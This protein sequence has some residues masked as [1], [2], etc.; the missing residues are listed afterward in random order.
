MKKGL[1]NRGFG[2]RSTGSIAALEQQQ[3]AA[4]VDNRQA[5]P[6]RSLGIALLERSVLGR[7][8]DGAGIGELQLGCG[9][10]RLSPRRSA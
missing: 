3:M 2:T 8:D 1:G 4:S 6:G 5:Y 10:H 9:A 7:F